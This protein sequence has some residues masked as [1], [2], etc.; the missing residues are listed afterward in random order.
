MG[1]NRTPMSKV[2]AIWI[3]PEFLCSIS[4]ISID[5]VPESDNRAKCYDHL[6][7]SRTSVVLFWASQ[8][9]M[10][11]NRTPMSKVMAVWIG[12]GLLCS[13]SSITIYYLP[14][15][16]ILVNSYDPFNFSRTSIFQ[17]RVSRYIMGLNRTTMP[18]VMA[19]WIWPELPCSISSV[20][21]YYV[22]E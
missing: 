6:H 15:S 22:S 19:V 10:G 4:S 11:V 2:M 18:K 21:I 3:G 8:Y 9:I 5:D 1:L 14:Q 17:F 7:F 20:L 12:P 16:D 13:I